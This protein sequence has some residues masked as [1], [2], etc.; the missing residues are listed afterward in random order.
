MKIIIIQSPTYIDILLK[1]KKIKFNKILVFDHQTAIFCDEKKLDYFYLKKKKYFSNLQ[2]L[3]IKS[4]IFAKKLDTIIKNKIKIKEDLFSNY[5]YFPRDYSIFLLLVMNIKNYISK[6]KKINF[7]F[8]YNE[9]KISIIDNLLIKV[10][11]TNKNLKKIKIDNALYKESFKFHLNTKF[12]R[13]EENYNFLTIINFYFSFTY[14]LLLKIFKK[15]INLVSDI[16]KIFLKNYSICKLKNFVFFEK[17]N[18]PELNIFKKNISNFIPYEYLNSTSSYLYMKLLLIKNKIKFLDNVFKFNVFFTQSPTFKNN[19]IINY[20]LKKN[21]R[22]Y[23][24]LHGGTTGHLKKSFFWPRLFP[25]INSKYLITGIYSRELINVNFIPNKKF[26]IQNQNIFFY[27]KPIFNEQFDYCYVLQNNFNIFYSFYQNFNDP[28]NLYNFRNKLLIRCLNKKNKIQFTGYDREDF[29]GKTVLINKLKKRKLF[30]Y[31]N[32]DFDNMFFN[33]KTIIFE[34]F[35][36]SVIKA[37]LQ[38]TNKNLVIL[39]NPNLNILNNHFK[40]LK[41]RFYFAKNY[42]EILKYISMKAKIDEKKVVLKYF[43]KLYGI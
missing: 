6:R 37:I 32:Y 19:I 39:L 26:F 5:S 10:S 38:D 18:Y 31:K 17:K 2:D 40:I 30:Y 23:L 7:Y 29:V 33:S 14:N 12:H 43:K 24:F 34:Q 22:V 3:F 13:K 1:Q 25:Y 9:N 11:D 8:Y 15:K 21:K 41:K 42:N 36:T 27:K 28:L 16:D 20:F 35:S 4:N